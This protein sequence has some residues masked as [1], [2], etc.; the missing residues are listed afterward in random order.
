[1][2]YFVTFRLVEDKPIVMGFIFYGVCVFFL[3]LL[4][5]KNISL[6]VLK[7][8]NYIIVSYSPPYAYRLFYLHLSKLNL[9][10]FHFRG[11]HSDRP[12]FHPQVPLLYMFILQA[13]FVG[14][15]LVYLYGRDVRNLVNY[16]LERSLV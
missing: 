9:V 1:M 11:K 4:F 10:C 14:L 2:I 13:K 12:C 3:F 5:L 8:K 7:K 15:F 16:R 6:Y